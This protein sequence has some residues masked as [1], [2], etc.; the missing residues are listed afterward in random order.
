MTFVLA[1][2]KRRYL[3]SIAYQLLHLMIPQC[4]DLV[5]LYLRQFLSWTD[6]A[7]KNGDLRG[8][9]FTDIQCDCRPFAYS[10]I[11]RGKKYSFGFLLLVTFKLW[12]IVLTCF[13]F[14]I[15]VSTND[16]ASIRKNQFPETV[17]ELR[18]TSQQ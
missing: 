5:S 7:G 15:I 18:S 11:Q 8:D 13:S 1:M 16:W 6:H 3:V 10:H 9:S 2:I 12:R 4:Q 17:L 14:E